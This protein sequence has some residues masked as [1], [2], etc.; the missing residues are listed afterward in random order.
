M[1]TALIAAAVAV[2]G[3]LVNHQLTSARDRAARRLDATLKFTERQLEEL[4][5]PLAVI[6]LSSRDTFRDLLTQLGRD[7]VFHGEHPLPPEEL[8]TWLFWV[9]HD[10][11][12]RNKRI[13]DLLMTKT[14][15][16]EADRFPESYLAFFQHHNS[17]VLRHERW[18]EQGIEYSFHSNTNWPQQFAEDVLA[19]FQELKSR[20]AALL[21]RQRTPSPKI[22]THVSRR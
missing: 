18:Q 8:K 5:G 6:L 1:A 13:A 10:A 9:E 17:W 14:H 12:P 11:F 20:H 15:L 4:Y 3:W 21:A 22:R 16:I 19:T 7:F 2:L